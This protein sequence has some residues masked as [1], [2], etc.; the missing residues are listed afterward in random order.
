MNDPRVNRAHNL[1]KDVGFLFGNHHRNLNISIII[2]PIILIFLLSGC[3]KFHIDSYSVDKNNYNSLLYFHEK[4]NLSSDKSTFEDTG[5]IFCRGAGPVIIPPQ[6]KTY[7]EY[8]F[9]ALKKEMNIRNAFDPN[10]KLLLTMKL[11][12]VDYETTLGATNWYI[13]G[14]Y[15]YK[16]KKVTI[17]TVYNMDSAFAASLACTNMAVHF[18]KVVSKHINQ[19]FVSDLFEHVVDDPH[20]KQN[21]TEKDPL[22]RLDRLKKAFDNKLISEK[23]YEDMSNNI[24]REF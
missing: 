22:L 20:K 18:P 23:E 16:G 3:G 9:D 7:T 14:E 17:S 11:T 21:V 12:K 13:D 1:E 6:N 19:L 8:I 24:L 10:S 15:T 5:E 4:I 2:L